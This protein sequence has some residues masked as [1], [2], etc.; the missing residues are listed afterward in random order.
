MKKKK[1]MAKIAPKVKVEVDTI[2]IRNVPSEV[3]QKF[4]EKASL[5]GYLPR[6][7]FEKIVK[8]L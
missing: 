1:V 3:K 6:E 5:L 7:F 8:G 2:Y 4:Y